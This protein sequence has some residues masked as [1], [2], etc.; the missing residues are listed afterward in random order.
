MA[1]GYLYREDGGLIDTGVLEKL[2][3]SPL[4]ERMRKADRVER[5]MRFCRN[6]PGGAG[7]HRPGAAGAGD[8]AHHGGRWMPCW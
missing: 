2:M 4:G 8:D 3:N 6:S 7:G 1:E 5:E